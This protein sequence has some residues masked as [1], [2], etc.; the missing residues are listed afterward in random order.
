MIVAGWNACNK[1]GSDCEIGVVTMQR[2]VYYIND[3]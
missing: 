3:V 1:C 2:N